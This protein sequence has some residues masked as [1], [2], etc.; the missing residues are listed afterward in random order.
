MNIDKLLGVEIGLIYAEKQLRSSLE[1]CNLLEKCN[2]LRI[3]DNIRKQ[4]EAITKL[5][6]SI[7]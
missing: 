6:M 1:K 4:R 3:I 7:K 5:Y 2:R